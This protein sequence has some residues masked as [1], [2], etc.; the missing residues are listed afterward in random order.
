[1]CGV[2]GFED[3]P[4][5]DAQLHAVLQPELLQHQGNHQVDDHHVGEQPAQREEEGR[6][7]HGKVTSVVRHALVLDI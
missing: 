1:M 5:L 4:A 7:L 2:G 6:G 3:H